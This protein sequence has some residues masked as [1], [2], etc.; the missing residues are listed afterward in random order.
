MTKERVAIQREKMLNRRR[1][2]SAKC[3]RVSTQVM[4]KPSLRQPLFIDHHPPLSVI[5]SEAEGSAVPRTIPGNVS[6]TTRDY[7]RYNL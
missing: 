7:I 5:P 3:T 4:R 6:I 2:H 1:F